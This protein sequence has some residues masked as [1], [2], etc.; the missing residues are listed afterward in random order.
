M[1]GWFCGAQVERLGRRRWHT[2]GPEVPIAHGEG[3]SRLLLLPPVS[4]HPQHL[5]ST[6]RRGTNTVFPRALRK[7]HVGATKKTWDM[8]AWASPSHTRATSH[9]AELA[10][11]CPS[12]WS[13]CRYGRRP[14]GARG[15]ASNQR[16]FMNPCSCYYKLPWICDSPRSGARCQARTDCRDELCR[17]YKQK[18]L[19][20]GRL[21][22]C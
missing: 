21:C 17:G 5:L 8:Q 6:A 1:D 15:N 7:A 20:W 12:S 9:G 19:L 3:Q 13:G 14:E 11:Q 4:N 22:R 16:F 10:G 2:V 18:R